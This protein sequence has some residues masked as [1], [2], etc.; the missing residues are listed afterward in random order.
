MIGSSPHDEIFEEARRE[1]QIEGTR[2]AILDILV[3]RFGPSAECLS[4][5][6]RAIEYDRLK[7]LVTFTAKC[8]NLASFR[9]RLL[10]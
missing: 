6:L 1:G 3:A 7:D 5:A 4:V 2:E 8:R 9:K 10:S